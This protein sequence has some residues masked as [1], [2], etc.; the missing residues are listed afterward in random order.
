VK[1][2]H[3]D[4]FEAPQRLKLLADIYQTRPKMKMKTES[5]VSISFVQEGSSKIIF[6]DKPVRAIELKK[7]EIFQISSFLASSPKIEC[8]TRSQGMPNIRQRTR[9][10]SH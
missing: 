5:G 3:F 8:D 7:E 2:Q 4:G 9:K 1:N 6:F 10:T